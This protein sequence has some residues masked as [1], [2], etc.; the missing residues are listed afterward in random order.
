MSWTHYDGLCRAGS[1]P[2]IWRYTTLTGETPEKM[3]A[4]IETALKWQ[5]EGHALPFTTVD[6]ASEQIAGST[7][8]GNIDK[9]HHRVE[10]GWTWIHPKWQRTYVNTEA[11]Y[12]LLR[13]AFETLGCMRVELKTDMLNVRSQKAILRLGAKQEGVFRNHMIINGRVRDSVYFS[14]IDTEWP[15]VKAGLEVMLARSY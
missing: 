15:E 1:D 8:F 4:Y 11:K 3:H 5:A 10:I 14:I 9:N 6:K 12:L 2:S 13:H 7:R